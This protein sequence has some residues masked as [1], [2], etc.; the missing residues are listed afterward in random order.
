MCS[1]GLG[2]C[3]LVNWCACL[4][5]CLTEIQ[6]SNNITSHS[7]RFVFHS[8]IETSLYYFLRRSILTAVQISM[9]GVGGVIATVVFRAQDA[10]RYI[11]GLFMSRSKRCVN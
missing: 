10:P 9:G 4:C 11:P 8:C 3:E 2:L 7:K 1:N 6:A 5:I